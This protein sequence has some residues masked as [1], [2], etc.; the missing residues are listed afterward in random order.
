MGTRQKFSVFVLT[1]YILYFTSDHKEEILTYIKE[2][3]LEQYYNVEETEESLAD[4]FP[5][6]IIN[7]GILEHDHFS[8]LRDYGLTS[9][10]ELE[11]L[12]EIFTQI[13]NMVKQSDH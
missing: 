8:L 12:E 3:K 5:K 4:S 7:K 1:Y 6:T 9:L 13:L 11:E 10:N 2:N